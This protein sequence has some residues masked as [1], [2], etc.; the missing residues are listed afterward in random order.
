MKFGSWTFKGEQLKFKFYLEMDFV[1]PTDYLKSGTWDIIDFPGE[2]KRIN[3]TESK[4]SKIEIHSVIFSPASAGNANTH[5][6]TNDIN[7]QGIIKLTV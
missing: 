1:D 3:D 4:A 5:I 6:L 2:I 7:T